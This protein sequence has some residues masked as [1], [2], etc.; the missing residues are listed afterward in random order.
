M[1]KNEHKNQIIEKLLNSIK[2]T[3]PPRKKYHSSIISSHLLD[4]FN[5]SIIRR[6]EQEEKEKEKEEG[7]YI[8]GNYLIKN[9]L[10][11]GTFGKVKLGI[12]IPTKEKVAVKILDKDKIFEKDDEIRLKREF[13][14]LVKFNN[15]NVIL[16][17]EIFWLQISMDN[18]QRMNIF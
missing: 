2:Q 1:P 13:D 10:G 14:M 7:E 5:E 18:S 9:T 15:L 17:S 16:I 6:L 11:Q 3:S 4:D 12:Y 8:I